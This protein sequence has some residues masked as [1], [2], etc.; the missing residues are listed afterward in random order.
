MEQV[1]NSIAALIIRKQSSWQPYMFHLIF[2]TAVVL[3]EFITNF[4]LVIISSQCVSDD[5]HVL[6]YKWDHGIFRGRI[7]ET[8]YINK[9][10]RLLHE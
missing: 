4:I 5:L 1:N 6:V 3:F 2:L 10:P 9:E 7:R 8:Y